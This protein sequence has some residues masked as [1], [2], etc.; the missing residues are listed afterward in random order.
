MYMGEHKG[1]LKELEDW[2][3]EKYKFEDE[4]KLKNIYP[5]KYEKIWKQPLSVDC[6][7]KHLGKLVLVEVFG[8]DD[9]WRAVLGKVLAFTCEGKR[10]N[11]SNNFQVWMVTNLKGK[12]I[13]PNYKKEYLDWFNILKGIVVDGLGKKIGRKVRFFYF[14][15]NESKTQ[16]FECKAANSIRRR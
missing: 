3:V 10:R 14:D 6:V 8:P 13:K 2:I 9:D 16:M 7:G 5:E 4:K 12:L 1:A 11:T 15:P